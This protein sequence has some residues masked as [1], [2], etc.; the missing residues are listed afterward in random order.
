MFGKTRTLDVAQTWFGCGILTRGVI[1]PA[2]VETARIPTRDNEGNLGCILAESFTTLGMIN[3]D[4]VLAELL[5]IESLLQD[6]RLNQQGRYALHRA[7]QALLNILELDTWHQAS[8]T[9]Y[10]I[11]NGP[12]EAAS[13]VLH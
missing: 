5:E 9:F 10:R 2:E 11:D 1:E 4:A 13:M 6:D 12:S 7:Q 8:R 3:R